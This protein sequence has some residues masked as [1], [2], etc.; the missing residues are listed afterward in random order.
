MLA[1]PKRKEIGSAVYAEGHTTPKNILNDASLRPFALSSPSSLTGSV[2][3]LSHNC[4][5]ALA[6]SAPCEVAQHVRARGAA[7]PLCRGFHL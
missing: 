5:Q 4:F 2:H 1:P 3:H 7:H 6:E